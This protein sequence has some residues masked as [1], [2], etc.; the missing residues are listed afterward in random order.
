M[1][2]DTSFWNK[3]IG[4]EVNQ[5]LMIYGFEML[6]L[7]KIW[8]GVNAANSSAHKS[9]LNA[10]FKEEGRLRNEVYRAGEYFDVV[11]MSI[12]RNEY[13]NLRKKNKSITKFFKQIATGETK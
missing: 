7:E 2:G 11:R 8:L 6:N 4:T 13:Q 12:L 10:G 5:L 3:G 9:Y 1:I